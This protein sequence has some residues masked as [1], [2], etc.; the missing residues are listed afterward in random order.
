MRLT[1]AWADAASEAEKASDE[2]QRFHPA[3]AGGVRRAGNPSPQRRPRGQ[4]DNSAGGRSDWSPTGKAL[5][6]WSRSHRRPGCLG[7]ASSKRSTWNKLA[8]ARDAPLRPR[9]RRRSAISPGGRRRG[10]ARGGSPRSSDGRGQGLGGVC[11]RLVALLQTTRRD[12]HASADARRLWREIKL[13]A[14]NEG[15]DSSTDPLAEKCGRDRGGRARARGGPGRVRA[16][17]S[18]A[19]QTARM[20]AL[21]AGPEKPAGAREVRTFMFTGIV[22]STA[23]AVKHR[24]KASVLSGGGRARLRPRSPRPARWSPRCP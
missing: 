3:M 22:G 5:C 19:W 8:R 7:Q 18:D 16:A 11:V 17:R 23:L 20:D 21:L 24:R 6:S 13:H 15:A 1:G 14:R 4:Q 10:G 12:G 2:L 9:S